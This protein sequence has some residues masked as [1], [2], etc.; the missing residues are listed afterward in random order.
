VRY[1]QQAGI[2]E[3]RGRALSLGGGIVLWGK[4]GA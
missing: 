2:E 3:V 4:R 1:W